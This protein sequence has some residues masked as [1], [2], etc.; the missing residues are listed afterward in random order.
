MNFRSFSEEVAVKAGNILL[1]KKKDF[2]VKKVKDSQQLDIATSADYA[3]EEF[4]ISQIKK[5]YPDHSIL[6]EETGFDTSL[7]SDY[8][9]IIDPLDGTKE[10]A[11]GIPYYYVLIAL[12]FK[13]KLI[14]AVAYQPEIKRMFSVDEKS[15]LNGKIIFPSKTKDLS[16]SFVSVALPSSRMPEK[17]IG[18]SL[19]IIKQ[20]CKL[21]YRIRNT[22]WDID[23][24]N[25]VACGAYDG[26]ITITSS[27]D[28]SHAKWWDVAPGILMVEKAGG[29]VTDLD[30]KEI[31]DKSLPNGIV[32]SN[33]L[34]HDQLISIVKQSK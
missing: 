8:Q 22:Q 6:A 12:E 24:L 32:A 28:I 10:Y 31:T 16:K 25:H 13:K 2:I 9:W 23:S 27:E 30:N 1:T 4:I 7:S 14:S 18:Q 11:R 26:Y 19:G 21:V 33:G 5:N 15:Y 20:L 34:I 17:A 3:S 29:K